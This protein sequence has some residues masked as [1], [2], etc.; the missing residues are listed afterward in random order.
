MI[1]MSS[2]AFEPREIAVVFHRVGG[3]SEDIS[4]SYWL[5]ALYISACEVPIVFL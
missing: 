3:G 5:G 1:N 2:L 4:Q